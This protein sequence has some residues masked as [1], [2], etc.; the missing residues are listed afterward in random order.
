VLHYRS[1]KIFAL[2]ASGL[3][4]L[5]ALC[6]AAALV[7][8]S[9]HD[10]FQRAGI[11]L[12][13]LSLL[14]GA[15]AWLL[16]MGDA[17]RT[18]RWQA[19]LGLLVAGAVVMTVV[20]LDM[21]SSAAVPG[22]QAYVVSLILAILL[23]PLAVLVYCDLVEGRP[24]RRA[25]KPSREPLLPK[26]AAEVPALAAL[27]EAR[28][29]TS[30]GE[31]GMVEQLRRPAIWDRLPESQRLALLDR[32]PGM[33]GPVAG[34]VPLLIDHAQ[35]AEAQVEDWLSQCV[36]ERFQ[37]EA[38]SV[39]WRWLRDG[40]PNAHLLVLGPPG[41]GRTSLVASLA[42][43]A[44]G[45]PV[46]VPALERPDVDIHTALNAA[47]G[48]V[49]VIS[50][51]H[52]LP[53]NGVNANWTRLLT[54]LRTGARGQ[55]VAEMQ[56]AEAPAPP[57]HP[58]QCLSVSVRVAVVGTPSAILTLARGT[59][60]FARMFRYLAE[61]K[62]GVDWTL[63]TESV[64]AALAAGMAQRYCLPPF[65]PAAVARLI[66]EGARRV[67]LRNQFR[68]T[69][70]LLVLHDLMVEAGRRARSRGAS[71]TGLLDVDEIMLR[72]RWDYG[73][74]AR[75]RQ[76]AILSGRAI[77]PT[78]DAAV[79][80]INGLSVFDQDPDEGSFGFPLRIS[81]I[82]GPGSEERLIDVEREADAADKNH[83]MGALTMSGYLTSRY[84]QQ[85][86]ISAAVRVRFEQRFTDGGIAVAG[87]S[88]SAAELFALL[89]A[90]AQVQI[91]SS[92][93]V[94]GAVGQYGEIQAI[95]GVNH[96]IEGFW[97]IC[98]KRRL[99][100]E[101]PRGPY[102]VLI[103]L[104][105]A[106]D[107]MLRPEVAE[108][109]AAGQFQVWAV[110]SVDEALPILTGVPTAEIH[111]RVAERLQRFYRVAVKAR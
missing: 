67:G 57:Q 102:G 3:W 53:V 95:G 79:G 12:L 69:A 105:N 13:A 10:F 92:L 41:H 35:A 27:P 5:G 84:G 106:S 81:A 16:A 110:R 20:M 21:L 98:Q 14:D 108:S 80:Q 60:E 58:E 45:G 23:L 90:L 56:T 99:M 65:E 11:V 94:T 87:P 97:E 2:M 88:A 78:A 104:A 66:E 64:Y 37:P 18:R 42:R 74:P 89:S 82:V 83:V 9:D 101:H 33:L 19:V 31:L 100:G 59:G 39:I 22:Y 52:L 47:H 6:V 85:H 111:R 49:L 4:A 62:R 43:R 51:V 17:M 73:A 29:L 86:P 25:P 36:V 7:F 77:V 38:A 30:P 28:V 109:I 55:T 48:G 61:F 93:A 54:A 75:Q 40:S 107:L 15:S 68:L 34:G 76:E 26:G 96:K 24:A 1:L 70:N 91:Y 32:Y 46:I 71:V 50:A 63:E 8:P 44:L 103:P 72:R